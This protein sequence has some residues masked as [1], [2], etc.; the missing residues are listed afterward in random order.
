MYN[1]HSGEPT[2]GMIPL[3]AVCTPRA[4]GNDMPV[5]LKGL[6]RSAIALYLFAAMAFS[7]SSWALP[8]GPPTFP[9]LPGWDHGEVILTTL[10]TP[11]GNMGYWIE[12]NYTRR[13]DGHSIDVVL[14][15]GP[16]TAW[17]GLQEAVSADD[18]PSGFRVHVQVCQNRR[19]Q[20]DP[21]MASVNRQG[22]C[23]R[24]GAGY[25]GHL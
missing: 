15:K 18:G 8:E 23:G 6:K 21:G 10:E 24:V 4:G 13:S 7:A 12:R 14:L 2:Y 22:P 1:I 20:G 17:Q 9:D 25:H 16:G 11:S 5:N 19:A 3:C